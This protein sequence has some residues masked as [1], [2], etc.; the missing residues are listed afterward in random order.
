[1][2]KLF[3]DWNK[4]SR[5]LNNLSDNAEQYKAV[6]ESMGY[7]IAERIWDIIE[8]QQPDFA[9]LVEEY[10]QDKIRDGYDERIAIRTGDYLNSIKVTRI[11]SDGDSLF[12][13]VGVEGGQTETGLDMSELAEYLEYGTSKQPARFPITQSW[14]I[15][16]NEITKEVSD[17]LK[18]IILGDIK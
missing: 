15:M 18:G 7:K 14:E 13:F 17:R 9:P 11:E 8:S 12:V 3:G 10:K 2:S 5:V 1:M 6:G 16:K 4:F